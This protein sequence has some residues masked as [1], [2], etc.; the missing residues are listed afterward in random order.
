MPREVTQFFFF[1]A[2]ILKWKNSRLP[3]RQITLVFLEE[4]LNK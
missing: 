2:Y 3:E 1:S 4:N